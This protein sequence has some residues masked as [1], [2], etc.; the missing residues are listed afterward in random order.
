MYLKLTSAD[1]KNASMITLSTAIAIFLA[2][3]LSLSQLIWVMVIVALLP[4]SKIGRTAKMRHLSLIG[5]GIASA[6]AVGITVLLNSIDWL[7]M[8]WLLIASFLLYCLP[9]YIPGSNATW[10]IYTDFH[11]YCA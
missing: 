6:L 4:F 2:K 1:I 10:F 7:V 11:G 5:T 8:T 9:R 3:W